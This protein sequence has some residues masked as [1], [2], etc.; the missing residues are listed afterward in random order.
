MSPNPLYG[1][2]KPNDERDINNPLYA[3]ENSENSPCDKPA[4]C[5]VNEDYE[6]RPV[7]TEE[8]MLD[9]PLYDGR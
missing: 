2:H 7:I 9:N 8:D 4:I 5:T 6:R 3:H 1:N